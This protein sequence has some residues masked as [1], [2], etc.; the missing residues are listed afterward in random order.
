MAQRGDGAG[1]YVGGGEVFDDGQA[2]C[3]ELGEGGRREMH[4]G[5]VGYRCGDLGRVGRG[6]HGRVRWS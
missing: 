6:W 4:G 3:E 2:E 5:G 1:G